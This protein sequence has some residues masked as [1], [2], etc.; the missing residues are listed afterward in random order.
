MVGRDGRENAKL[1]KQF[2]FSETFSGYVEKKLV[3]A[4]SYQAG[5]R[6]G[7]TKSAEEALVRRG[8][9]APVGAVTEGAG[10]GVT[11]IFA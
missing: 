11:F 3:L 9:P 5:S 6:D 4:L 1:E 2:Q 10:G 8:L 7:S